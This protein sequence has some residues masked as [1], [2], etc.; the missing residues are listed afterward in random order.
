[1]GQKSLDVE[2]VP[3][4]TVSGVLIV[5]ML[6][7]IVF[8]RQ[9]GPHTSELQNALAAVQ[10]RQL[11]NQEAYSLFSS[12]NSTRFRAILLPKYNCAVRVEEEYHT[13]PGQTALRRSLNCDSP[14]MRN[15]VTRLY[16]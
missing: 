9:E 6:G 1:M 10:H 7:Q 15:E 8:L 13:E 2:R 12:F 4:I 14:V 16:K 11:V 5:R 3:G